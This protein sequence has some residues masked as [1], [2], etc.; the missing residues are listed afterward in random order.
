M[1]YRSDIHI[2][3]YGEADKMDAFIVRCKMNGLHAVFTKSGLELEEKWIKLYTKVYKGWVFKHDYIKWYDSYPE[4]IGM[5]QILDLTEEMDVWYEMMRVGENIEDVEYK[6]SDEKHEC[7]LMLRRS[8]DTD[9]SEV[10]DPNAEAD[11]ECP[12]D[13]L[14]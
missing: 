3:I 2:V 5:K 8:I 4:V 6:Y 1:G 11:H 9:Y 7:I 10:K 13:A 14:E 12:T